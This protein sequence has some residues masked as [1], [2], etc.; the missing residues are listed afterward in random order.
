MKKL[1]I[2]VLYRVIQHWR[3]PIFEKIAQVDNV[4]FKILH[5]PD[6]K[7]TKVVNSTGAIPFKSK[8]L[9]SYKLQKQSA[10]GL[11]AMP[12]SPFLFF[13]LCFQQPDVILTEGAS[14]FLN[15]IQG[16]AYCK[17]FGKKYIWWSL[18]KLQKRDYD[19]SRKKIDRI[20][21][22]MEKHSDAIVSYSTIGK[23]YFLAIGV[24]EERIFVAVNVVDTASKLAAL[25]TIDTDA[26]YREFHK[27]HSFNVLFVGA[28][29]K[30]KNIEMLIKAFAKLEAKHT[31]VSLNIV[32][33]GNHSEVLKALSNKL[34]VKK[35]NFTGNM[36]K[37]VENYFIGSDVFVLPGLGGLAVSEAMTYGLPVIAS[38]GDGCE[39]DLIDETNG[40]LDVDL[41][42]DSLFNYL[43]KLYN[44][45]ELLQSL[46]QNAKR[47]IEEQYNVENYVKQIS[48]AINYTVS[49]KS[50]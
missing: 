49:K 9:I 40:L 27:N 21:Q 29:N 16:F 30:E 23:Q 31:D 43:E 38:I 36:I 25:K 20:V 34:G 3:V 5:G 41:N 22:Y 17:L 39:A 35:I 32:G 11:I 1:K 8:K 50:L 46:K 24:P 15:A 47:K 28:L 4:D 18:G 37:G 12:F 10:N 6:F 14:N 33:G 7:G 19:V 44:D 42:E 13:Y 26:I 2:F 48:N 45:R